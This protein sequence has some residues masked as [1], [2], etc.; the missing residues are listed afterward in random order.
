M[1]TGSFSAFQKTDSLPNTLCYCVAR[2]M[3]IYQH[4]YLILDR[5]GFWLSG[6]WTHSDSKM[7][8][9]NHIPNQKPRTVRHGQVFFSVTTISHNK[10]M[11]QILAQHPW[12][13]GTTVLKQHWNFSGSCWLPVWL[14][15][16]WRPLS[17]QFLFDAFISLI[18]GGKNT[19]IVSVM[20]TKPSTPPRTKVHR[21][22]LE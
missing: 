1:S 17:L 18:K 16:F 22:T 21:V 9:S 6:C 4:Q 2:Y 15:S 10:K 12:Q 11:W 20:P 5:H 8:I 3:H 19:N 13:N 14:S 7:I